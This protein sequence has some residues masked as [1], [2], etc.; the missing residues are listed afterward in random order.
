[1]T[2]DAQRGGEIETFEQRLGDVP[3]I[4]LGPLPE[5]LV[6]LAALASILAVLG[7]LVIINPAM[8][9]LVTPGYAGLLVLVGLAPIPMPAVVLAG[10]VGV[11]AAVGT[12]GG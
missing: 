7:L 9:A 1:M 2:V 12:R 10:L 3:P 6:E 4:D 11:L 8:A 5:Q